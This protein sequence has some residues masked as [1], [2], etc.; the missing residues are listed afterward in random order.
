M[1][2]QGNALYSNS[3]YDVGIS[4]PKWIMWPLGFNPPSSYIFPLGI[5]NLCMFP[6]RFRQ[7]LPR[8]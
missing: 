3:P 5:R 4:D 8:I 7:L 2:S 1:D 6:F